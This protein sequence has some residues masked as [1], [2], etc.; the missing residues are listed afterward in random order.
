VQQGEIDDA[1]S[2]LT[3]RARPIVVTYYIAD[4]LGVAS[5]G[6]MHRQLGD[7][8]RSVRCLVDDTVAGRA[9]ASMI[10]HL[11][12]RI[13]LLPRIDDPDRMRAVHGV[14]RSGESCAFPVDG[15]GPYREVGTGIVGLA[16]SLKAMIV[17]IAARPT[18]ALVV[19]PQ[20]R[21]R[22]PLPWSRVVGAIGAGVQV[23]RT[24]DRRAVANALKGALDELATAVRTFR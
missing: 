6:L 24:R 13:S 10:A 21:V 15:G 3:R 2:A 8:L 18:P 7:L 22:V 12:G 1:L 23:D 11:G 17:P 19:A 20:S 16:A 5:L 9:C 4:A 14:I